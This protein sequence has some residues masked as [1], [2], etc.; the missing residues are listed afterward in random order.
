MSQKKVKTSVAQ[1]TVSDPEL[2][3]MFNK[4]VGASEPDPSIVIPKYEKIMNNSL[5]IIQILESFIKS[6]CAMTFMNDFNKAF[7]EIRDFINNSNAQ[8]NELKLEKNDKILSGAD[9]NELNSHPEKIQ[10]Y[11]SNLDFKYKLNRLGEFWLKLKDSPVVK[12]IIM[13]ARNFKNALMMEKQRAGTQK[14][15]LED[16]DHLSSS[17][18]MK[19]DGDF[20]ILF[21]FTSLDFK[22]LYYHEFM[23]NNLSKYILFVLHLI[24]KKIMI[25]VKEI[26]SPDIDV[27][28][29]SQLL[30]KN[31]DEI[32]KHIPRCDKAFDK[33]KQSV[34]LLKDN[35]GEYYK[36][37]ISSQN[38]GIIVEH[39]VLD[40]AKSSNADMA[41][42]R[43][44]RDIIAFYKKNMQSRIKDPKVKKIFSMVGS[45]LDILEDKASKKNSSKVKKTEGTEKTEVDEPEPDKED[46]EEDK[47]EE[48]EEETETDLDDLPTDN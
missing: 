23:N 47:E 30:V 9:L 31:I 20:M 4:M 13:S 11:L 28:K 42:T 36:D 18:I 27:D 33:I 41:T 16:K 19:S 7:M 15:D 5:E 1:K 38:P 3:D 37:F 29:F 35:F 48:R 8:L 2:I 22:Q 6:P 12:E 17:F 34:S 14:H 32:R 40:V 39:F 44:F 24:H 10:E 21:N 26:T 45:N 43:Q 25:I 46:K